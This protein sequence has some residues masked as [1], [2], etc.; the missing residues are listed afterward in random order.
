MRRKLNII[1]AVIFFV[2]NLTACS[3]KTVNYIPTN[4][5]DNI[6]ACSTECAS[7][8][9][10][11]DGSIIG[12]MNET[13]DTDDSDADN[14][15]ENVYD[16]SNAN[17]N[18]SSNANNDAED[19]IGNSGDTETIVEENV[20]VHV[21]G[22]VN[23]PGLYYMPEDSLKADA[24]S[25]AGGFTLD[26]AVDYVNLAEMITYGEKI[27]FPYSYEL[28]DGYNLN[29]QGLGQGDDATSNLV[30]INT[31]TKDELMTL[32][33]IGESKAEAIIKYRESNGPFQSTED[34]TNIPG[35]KEG[36]YNNI[37]EHIVVN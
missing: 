24:L 34:I 33:G 29:D 18:G 5:D 36:V 20:P 25:M 28:E 11:Q 2:L 9:V 7:E 21:C 15:S 1:C 16:D 32:P 4:A 27:Y 31:A 23:S 17:Y 3:K 37:K 13:N 10:A 6:V 8:D 19:N 30:N 22:A 14:N 26:A 35:I 12:S